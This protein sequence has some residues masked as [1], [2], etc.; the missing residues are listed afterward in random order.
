MRSCRPNKQCRAAMVRITGGFQ[1]SRSLVRCICDDQRNASMPVSIATGGH[2]MNAVLAKQRAQLRRP[3]STTRNTDG[4]L[5]FFA[6]VNHVTPACCSLRATF[7]NLRW[8]FFTSNFAASPESSRPAS[9]AK[10]ASN[11]SSD[12][13]QWT[14]CFP[15]GR[16][17]FSQSRYAQKAISSLVGGVCCGSIDDITTS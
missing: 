13:S 9:C 15:W 8:N 6:D 2:H 4:E 14:M 12:W 10:A 3:A 5:H 16:P 7:R 1:N 17:S 11:C